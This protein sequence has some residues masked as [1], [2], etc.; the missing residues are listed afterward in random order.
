MNITEITDIELA[1]LA[2]NRLYIVKEFFSK[3]NP[4]NI[5]Q[6]CI[7]ELKEILSEYEDRIKV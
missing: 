7:D 4:M 5:I 1:S 6:N 2:L 3:K